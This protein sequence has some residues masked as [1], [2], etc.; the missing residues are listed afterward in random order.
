MKHP[1]ETM[2][3]LAGILLL[4]F[5]SVLLLPA[6]QLGMQLAQTLMQIF[7][8]LDLNQFYTLLYCL[9]FLLLGTIEFYVLRFI[10]RRWLAV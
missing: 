3:T 10:W 6:P 4:S 8:L 5:V 1:L 2:V 9:W 7:H